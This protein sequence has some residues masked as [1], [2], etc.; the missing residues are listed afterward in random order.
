MYIREILCGYKS[1]KAVAKWLFVFLIFNIPITI[2]Q[3]AELSQAGLSINFLRETNT[4][5]LVGFTSLPTD[6][7]GNF[8][9]AHAYMSRTA[10]QYD[11]TFIKLKTAKIVGA[12]VTAY[13]ADVGDCTSEVELLLLSNIE[14]Q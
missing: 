8:Q 5:M 10:P 1:L 12:P 7:A 3:A 11:K 13:Y 9:G 4:G 2:A 6:C 14:V